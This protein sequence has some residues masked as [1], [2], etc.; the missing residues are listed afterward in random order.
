MFSLGTEK[1]FGTLKEIGLTHHEAVVYL[2]LLTIGQNPASAIAKKAAINRSSCHDLL[3]KLM[4]KGFAREVI[5]NNI[6][7][8]TAVELKLVLSELEEKRFQIDE[9][10]NNIGSILAQ[11][12]IIQ[13]EQKGKS[14]AVFF[15]GEAGVRNIM[16]DTLTA[17]EE[18]RAYASFSELMNLLPNYFKNYAQKRIQ[19]GIPVRA[20]Y[21]ANPS[22]LEHKK[23][24]HLELRQS[25]LIPKI[26]DFHLDILMYDNKVAITSLK[27][28]FGVLIESKEI[29]EAQKRIFDFIWEGTKKYDEMITKENATPEKT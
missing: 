27:E 3:K 1:L 28:K 12:E 23:R 13:N 25:R 8:Y 14:R 4:R 20:I 29:A 26:F 10:I 18:L 6:S 24:D 2:A 17:K 7:Y 5:K 15:E 16:E 19:K 11:F 22:S 21:P 9:K